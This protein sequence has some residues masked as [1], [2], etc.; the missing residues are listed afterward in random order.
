M[1]LWLLLEQR[2]RRWCT[3]NTIVTRGSLTVRVR[4]PRCSQGGGG[5]RKTR[6]VSVE[7]VTVWEAARGK[8]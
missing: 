4:L 8:G 5:G 6:A 2:R 3:E 1:V 7:T